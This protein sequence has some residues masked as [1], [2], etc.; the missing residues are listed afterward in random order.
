MSSSE[1]STAV[2]ERQTPGFVKN[3]R[4]C[5][6]LCLVLVCLAAAGLLLASAAG[7]ATGAPPP[8]LAIFL[9]LI[10]VV[11]LL[12]S[13]SAQTSIEQL[14]NPHPVQELFPRPDWSRLA[15][16]QQIVDFS[17]VPALMLLVSWAMTVFVLTRMPTLGR[18]ADY[19]LMTLLWLLALILYMAAIAWPDWG[20]MAGWRARLDRLRTGV[21]KWTQVQT[22][23]RLHSSI[24]ALS[25]ILVVAL[26]LRVVLLEEIPFTL[27]GDESS[28]GLEAIRVIEGVITNPFSTGW[29]G[30]PT[31]SFYFNSLTIRLFGATTM[32][33]R[34]PWALIGTVTVLATYL[35]VKRLQNAT[36]ALATAALIAVYHYHIHFSRLGSNQ[37]ASPLFMALALLFLYRA[38]D[39][40]RPVDWALTG[41][42]SAMALYFY[43]GARLT[44]IVIV[45][46]LAYLFIRSPRH[47]WRQHNRGLLIMMGAFLIAGAPILQY[48]VRYP[49][50]FNS[51]VNQVGIIQSGWLE[52]QLTA[53]RGLA[54]TLLDQF[55]RAVLAFN[56]YPDRTVWYGLR[57]PLLDTA[58]GV[59]FLVGLGYSTIA[60]FGD[61]A[62]QRLAPLVIWWW[63]GVFL[64]GMLAE[65]PPSSMRLVILSLPVCFFIALAMWRIIK[66]ADAA[67]TGVPT[68]ALLTGGV[69][70]FCVIS[71]KTYFLDFTPQRLYGGRHAELSTTL[72]PILNEHQASHIV[73]FLGAPNMIW[74]FPTIGYLVPDV[75]GIDLAQP[76]EE[77]FPVD[78]IPPGRGGMFV[79]LPHRLDELMLVQESLPGGEVRELYGLGEEDQLMATVYI[80][81]NQ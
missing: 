75:E 34:L 1:D 38:L 77:P 6:L 14:S 10:A 70:L 58:F 48:A 39:E 16:T 74:E 26:L 21:H 29:F 28:Q 19:T 50:D 41:I 4:A 32:A 71:L 52:E 80:V 22:W 67:M 25:A 45:A 42:V 44:P 66:L 24:L 63:S 40:H 36:L 8:W 43:A 53:G 33:L 60:M 79:F 5:W 61:K 76:L 51:R 20:G 35:L 15:F 81:P 7:T 3:R 23:T 64:G 27:G 78:R 49:D 62:K 72:A 13:P 68:K 37:I 57:Q 65:S 30:V 31:L 2:H 73:Y 46:V 12:R 56:Y 69:L 11:A 59:I 54:E 18:D 55:T 9:I 17:L 47:F